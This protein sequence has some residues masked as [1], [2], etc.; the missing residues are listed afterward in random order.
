[1]IWSIAPGEQAPK[2]LAT[3]TGRRGSIGS[4]PPAIDARYVYF[5]WR[6]DPADIWVMD[7]RK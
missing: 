2:R 7:V 1:M 5:P 4:Q 6:E 3:L